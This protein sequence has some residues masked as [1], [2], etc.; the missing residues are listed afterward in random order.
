[1]FLPMIRSMK[2][3]GYCD[4]DVSLIF[5]VSLVASGHRVSDGILATVDP[6][7]LRVAIYS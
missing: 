3:G 4:G 6:E 5:S 1:M 7:A 2:F